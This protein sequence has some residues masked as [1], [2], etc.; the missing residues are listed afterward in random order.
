MENGKSCLILLFFQ[1]LV[2]GI[3]IIGSVLSKVLFVGAGI[4]LLI[5]LIF[6]KKN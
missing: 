5:G 3:M 1:L 4:F 6:S 2:I